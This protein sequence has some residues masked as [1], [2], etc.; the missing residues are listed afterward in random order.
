MKQAIGMMN[1][2]SFSALRLRF[3]VQSSCVVLP[4]AKQDGGHLAYTAC[5]AAASKCVQRS[6]I[7]TLRPHQ[8]QCRSNIR[9]CC[10]KQQHC[11][12]KFRSFDKVE[13]N[14]TCSICFDIVERTKFRSTILPKP[15]TLLPKT[16]TMSK[17]RS[18]LSK[19]Q[20]FN[21]KLVEHCCR[22][23]QQCRTLL[24]YCCWCG[25]GLKSATSN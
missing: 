23:W 4:D 7:R 12:T 1:V 24:R 8:Q 14:W 25:P 19:G 22:F 17:Q 16:A 5:R 6:V 9:L 13:T 21:A 10:H 11:R 20:K 3:W 2:T 18:T 15:A